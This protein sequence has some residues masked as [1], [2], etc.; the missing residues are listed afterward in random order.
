MKKYMTIIEAS[1][2][3]GLSES[4][5]YHLSAK[6]EIPMLK[7]GS[8]VLIPMDEFDEWLQKYKCKS[9]NKGENNA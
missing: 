5:L 3:F 4:T 7:Y 1:K 8:K 2:Y 6:R 9:I